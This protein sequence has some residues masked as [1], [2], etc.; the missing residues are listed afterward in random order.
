MKNIFY[1]VVLLL[2]VLCSCTSK[3]EVASPNG[4]IKWSFNLDEK[5]AMSYQV[6]VN[7]APFINASAL[8]F[9]EKSGLNLKDGFQLEGTTFDSQDE[10]WT[11]PW[12][13][14]KSI[15]SHYN[16]MAVNLKNE[17]GVKLTVRVRVF[18]DGLGFRYEYET[19]ADS[20]LL[21]DEYTSFNMAEDGTSWSIPAEFNTYE[22]LYRTM[23]LSEMPDANTPMTFK[24]NSGVYASIHEAAL[25]DFPEMCL[26]N[27]GGTS[28]KSW[29]AAWPDK[30][31][32][33]FDSGKFQTPWRSV[34]IADRP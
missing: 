6:S 12:G 15:R 7:N 18:D 11:Q 2:L 19:P 25:T 5:G 1:S 23:P 28:L 33:R 3:T 22:L 17:A 14:N 29:L 24:T 20:L 4:N 34:Q 8:G 30:V 21:M 27:V 9:E 10:T 13:E 32:A 16:E 26:K 31:K